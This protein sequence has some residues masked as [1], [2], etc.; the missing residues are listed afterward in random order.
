MHWPYPIHRL[1]LP[2]GEHTQHPGKA[3]GLVAIDF[4]DA[5]MWLCASDHRHVSHARKIDVVH[6]LAFTT[7]KPQ[8]F[9]PCQPFTYHD[10]SLL[11]SPLSSTQAS[12]ICWYPVQRQMWP[13]MKSRMRPSEGAFSS[14]KSAVSD[15]KIPEV[16]YPHCSP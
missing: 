15:I 4:K 12:I 6:K 10:I 1:E 3:T 13:W 16:Q 8:V 5:G 14:L 2:S 11:R 7:Q 9:P